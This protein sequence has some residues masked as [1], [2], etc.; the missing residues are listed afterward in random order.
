MD[1]RLA[2]DQASLLEVTRLISDLKKQIEV[3]KLQS[4]QAAH[5]RKGKSRATGCCLLARLEE[6][7]KSCLKTRDASNS[8]TKT[9]R[10]PS[11]TRRA[12]KELAN[13]EEDPNKSL[14]IYV[15]SMW[16]SYRQKPKKSNE[17]TAIESRIQALLQNLVIVKRT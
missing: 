11:A 7:K 9:D 17:R 3:A 5:S 6:A 13:Y 4:S 16:S 15:S 2:E 8:S 1:E 12:G 14:S 10:E